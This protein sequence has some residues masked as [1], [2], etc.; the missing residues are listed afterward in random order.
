MNSSD[1]VS[2]L[3]FIQVELQA[4]ALGPVVQAYFNSTVYTL[5]N[6]I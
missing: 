3:S 2:S 1:M 5:Y 6:L 4:G